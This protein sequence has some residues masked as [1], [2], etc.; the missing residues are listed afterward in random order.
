[1]R[2]C[3]IYSNVF[4][5]NGKNIKVGDTVKFWKFIAIH[6]NS[7]DYFGTEPENSFPVYEE[8]MDFVKGE[9]IYDSGAFC[10]KY[11]DEVITLWDIIKK[12]AIDF[13]MYYIAEYGGEI[14]FEN[15]DF[16]GEEFED[17]NLY[18][19][20]DIDSTDETTV[21]WNR[22]KNHINKKCIEFEI[23]LEQT[24][25]KI[26][27]MSISLNVLAYLSTDNSE[28]QKHYEAVKF[29][30][31]INLSFPKETSEFFKG[32]VNGNDLEDFNSNFILEYLRYGVNIPMKT[33]YNPHG[34]G[35]IIKV[36]DIPKEAEQIV[37]TYS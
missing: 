27:N 33:S 4:D 37:I 15:E 21:R 9:V 34:D 2:N 7:V 25:E 23:V 36:S 14:N 18:E 1:M 6:S 24:K 13:E 10:I 8:Y 29:C 19:I 5:I 20:P 12:T 11:K 22:I 26:E 35:L 16:W 32:K 17:N 30:I 3:N 28:F 31:E